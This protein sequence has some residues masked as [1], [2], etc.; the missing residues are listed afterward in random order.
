M[1]DVLSQDNDALSSFF[2]PSSP[3]MTTPPSEP[4]PA[5]ALPN[6]QDQ[7][8]EDR[9]RSD[10][11]ISA[12][13]QSMGL[14]EQ[15]LQQRQREMEPL[16]QRAIAQAQQPLPQPPKKQQPPATPQRQS[17]HDDEN[18]L[19]ASALLGSLA[20][21]FTRRHQTNALAAFSGA[22]EG[23]QEGSRQKFDQSM[24]L[25]EAE[26]KKAL[27][28]NK[29]A[30]DEYRE[31]L[32]NRKYSMDQMSI[33]M[34]LAGQKY[35][36][37]AAIEAAKTKNSHTIAQFYDKRAQ[38]SEEMELSSSRLLEQ[39]RR[40]NARDE[41]AKT[42]RYKEAAEQYLN[43]QEGQTR[44]E[45]T[46]KLLRPPPSQAVP[47]NTAM[48][49]REA[50]IADE[51][52]ARGLDFGAFKRHATVETIK[53]TT[54]AMAERRAATQKAAVQAGRE[55]QLELIISTTDALLPRA[56]ASA[57]AIPATNFPSIN[58]L[59]SMVD[60]EI[61]NP[62][63]IRLKMDTLAVEE[64]WA[65]AMN[66]TGQ[67]TVNNVNRAHSVM[68]GAYTPETYIAALDELHGLLEL[69]QNA[70]LRVG[71]H[72]TLPPLELPDLKS[73]SVGSAAGAIAGRA[74]E[75][76]GKTVPPG[77]G[78]PP[79]AAGRSKPPLQYPT[80]PTPDMPLPEGW[81]VKELQ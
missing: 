8:Q 27:E 51:L 56:G 2:T 24:R 76:V 74:K 49:M 16:R 46:M 14:E 20:G 69:E 1:P 44:I 72:E 48:G 67:M 34:Q 64:G 79:G 30:M 78:L 7:I 22:M 43:S 28:T 68:G 50:M 37:N 38:A 39:E 26:N 75:A 41:A 17:Q 5:A 19:F 23:Y 58:K 42:A 61:G 33:A 11:A 52:S 6:R 21:A 73:A 54:P 45:Q 47:R 65:R 81:S 62:A 66:P 77:M 57:A 4:P 53:A 32:E 71:R 15:N 9:R 3:M 70:I 63:L 60:T 25:W 18:W 59:M 12:M 80:S 40:A 36:D 55:A 31:I 35:D 10:E 13:K 29:Q